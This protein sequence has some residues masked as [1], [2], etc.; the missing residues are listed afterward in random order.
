M[1]AAAL[2]LAASLR[3]G[4]ADRAAASR[5]LLEIYQVCQSCH[6][7]FAPEENAD[8]RKYAPEM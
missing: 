3:R 5:G 4:D 2:R 7:I 8:K 6:E 1:R